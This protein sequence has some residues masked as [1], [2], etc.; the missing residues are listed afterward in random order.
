MGEDERKIRGKYLSKYS[1]TMLEETAGQ[2]I[3]IYQ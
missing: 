1:L 3:K 2:I